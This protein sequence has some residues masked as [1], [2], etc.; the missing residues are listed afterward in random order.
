MFMVLPSWPTV[1]ARIHP[2]HA[3]NAKQ[4]QVA[5]NIWTKPTDVSHKPA[6]RQLENYIH[7]RHLLLHVL[8]PKADTRFSVPRRVE[9]WV[10]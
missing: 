3:I 9:G 10:A 5:A 4:R 6:C 2:V 8:S 1:T 7:H